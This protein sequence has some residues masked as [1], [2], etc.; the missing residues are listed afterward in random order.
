MNPDSLEGL[1][2]YFHQYWPLEK[3]GGG[4]T[5]LQ[6]PPLFLDLPMCRDVSSCFQGLRKE[7][8]GTY[9]VKNATQRKGRRTRATSS[10]TK[11]T[12]THL[13]SISTTSSEFIT[14]QVSALHSVTRTSSVLPWNN[15]YFVGANVCGLSKF[16]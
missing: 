13:N 5:T 3:G 7:R 10:L 6:P 4:S 12:Q 14:S 1:F 15:F 16:C 11:R 2:L 8:S 9:S